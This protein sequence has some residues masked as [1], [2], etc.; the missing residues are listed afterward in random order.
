MSDKELKLDQFAESVFREIGCE[1]D[2]ALIETYINFKRHKDFLQPGRLTAEG[3]A[4]IIA[5][6]DLK[7]GCDPVKAKKPQA[8]KTQTKTQPEPET[9]EEVE[10]PFGK[11]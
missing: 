9:E 5:I 11:D 2:E 4:F 7:R 3:Y 10:S 6:A 1:I 8:K